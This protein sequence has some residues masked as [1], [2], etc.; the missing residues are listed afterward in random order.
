M[1]RVGFVFA[2]LF[3]IVS[4]VSAQVNWQADKAHSELQFKVKHFVITT[5]TGKFKDYSVKF[6]T[7]SADDFSDAELETVIKTGSIFTDNDRR[8]NHLRSDDF[9]NAEKYPE[10]AFVSKSFEKTGDNTYK[11]VGDLTIRDIT[12]SV[13]LTAEFGGSASFRGQTR[14]AFHVTGEINRF[15]YDVKWDAKLDTGGFIVSELI[16]FDFNLEFVS[17]SN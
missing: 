7:K 12:K 5:I 14:I 17:Q 11:V 10:I 9:L 1:K 6:T 15:D 3:F 16:K 4:S 13:E 8:D 2:V